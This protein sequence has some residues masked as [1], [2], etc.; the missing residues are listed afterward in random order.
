M[1]SQFQGAFLLP[2]MGQEFA[3]AEP[4][5]MNILYGGTQLAQLTL[6]PYAVI[7]GSARDAGNTGNTTVLRKG[8][9]MGQITATGKWKQFDSGAGDGSQFARGILIYGNMNTQLNGANA[10]RFNAFILVGKCT[11]NAEGICLASS[12]TYGLAKTGVGQ[13]VRKHFMYNF[14]FSDDFAGETVTAFGAR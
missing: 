3:T 4:D 2:G 10:D 12:A 14:Q 8:L 13:T 5:F 11:I 1:L 9:V 6:V 7:D